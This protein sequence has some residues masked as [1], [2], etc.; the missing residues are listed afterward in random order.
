MKTILIVLGT[1]LV[2]GLFVA[3]VVLE[4]YNSMIS[5]QETVKAQLGN[6]KNVYQLRT[7]LIPSIVQTV[8]AYA[9]HENTTLVGVT[10]ARAKATQVTLKVDNIKQFDQN[11]GEISSTLSRLLVSVEKYP[12]LKADKNFRKLHD[13]LSAVNIKIVQERAV[14]NKMAKNQ[15]VKIKTFPNSIIAGF[16]NF[17]E[18]TYFEGEAGVEKTPVIS[19]D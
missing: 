11:Q 6:V 9:K 3:L 2:A 13:E 18:F 14:Y 7:D 1:L 10:E 12:D 5:G 4:A 16:G 15:N 19:F 17:K 8:K